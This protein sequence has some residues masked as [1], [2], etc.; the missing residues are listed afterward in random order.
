MLMTNAC[1][2]NHFDY[3]NKTYFDRG[4]DRHIR[5]S[6]K[7]I[8]P[9]GLTTRVW[10]QRPTTAKERRE[11]NLNKKSLCCYYIP[12]I[13]IAR[14]LRKS[15]RLAIQTLFHEMV[16]AEM[17]ENRI[18]H[19]KDACSSGRWNAFNRRMLK[20]AKQGAFNGWW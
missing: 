20:L 4:L 7:R 8:K 16:H 14:D 17:F 3:L 9:L 18:A 1:L 15:H 10:F 12:R 19:R 11:N 6:F 2:Q 5:V 13:Y